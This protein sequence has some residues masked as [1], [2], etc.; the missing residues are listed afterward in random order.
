MKENFKKELVM[1]KEDDENFES[2]TKCWICDNTSVKDD[3][4]VR[5]HFLITAK[6]RDSSH[7]DF[8]INFNISLNYKILIMFHNLEIYDSY[9]KM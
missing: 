6:C 1:N 9:L 4:K 3:A 8:N 5:D 2:S 7:R